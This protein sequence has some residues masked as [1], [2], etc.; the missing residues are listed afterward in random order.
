MSHIT[1]D[2]RLMSYLTRK[3]GNTR[4]FVLHEAGLDVDGGLMV[5]AHMDGCGDPQEC[6]E[7]D[8]L[9]A[10]I[11][12]I[13]EQE[14]TAHPDIYFWAEDAAGNTFDSCTFITRI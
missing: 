10:A 5:F 14:R 1:V 13:V 8:T 2:S 12:Y 4:A 3:P 11:D 9:A 7:F 6:A